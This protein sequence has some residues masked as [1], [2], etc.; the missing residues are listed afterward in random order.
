[1]VEQLAAIT[2]DTALLATNL[3]DWDGQRVRLLKKAARQLDAAGERLLLVIDGLDEDRGAPPAGQTSIASL[4]PRRPPTGTRILVT[5]RPHPGIPTDVP[6]HPLRHSHVEQLSRSDQARR[7][8]LAAKHELTAHL[9]SG[10]AA[11]IDILGLLT[12]AGGGLTVS[13]LAELIG[14]PRWEIDHQVTGTFGRS[15]KSR[16]ASKLETS[17]SEPVLIFGHEALREQAQRELFDVVKVYRQRIDIWVTQYR[18]CGWPQESPRFVFRRY[19]RLLRSTG[20]TER[21]A[22]LAVDQCRHDQMLLLTFGDHNA[23]E[24]VIG[25]HRAA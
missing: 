18:D 2:G 11:R 25:A 1:M 20:D 24:E 16:S 22:E 14:K 13:E 12:A 19:A 21:L 7:I 15:L 10:D 9:A 4:L 17:D 23:M 5:S 6:D 3:K 8:E